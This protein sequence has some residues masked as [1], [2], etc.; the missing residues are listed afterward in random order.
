M[1]M[2]PDHLPPSAQ[3]CYEAL[4]TTARRGWITKRG[5]LKIGTA[6]VEA[7]WRINWQVLRNAGLIDFSIRTHTN[8][9]EVGGSVKFIDWGF[10]DTD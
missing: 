7:N 1:T 10:A 2:T 8:R 9:P 5:D 3:T 6:A 4:R